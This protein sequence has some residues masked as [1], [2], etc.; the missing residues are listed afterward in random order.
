MDIQL[1]YYIAVRSQMLRNEPQS[2]VERFTISNQRISAIKRDWGAARSMAHQLAPAERELSAFFTAVKEM[3]GGEEAR[4]AT[5]DWIEELARR[6]WPN[7]APVEV[8]VID[9]RRVTI[10]AAAR[11]ACRHMG[12]LARN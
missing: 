7:E 8:P 11:L 1:H 10:A 5:E 12:L 6:D 2:R 9:W 4:R 3:F